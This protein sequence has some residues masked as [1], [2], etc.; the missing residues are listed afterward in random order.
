MPSLAIRVG[1][2]ADIFDAG[3]AS[4][5]GG[6]VGIFDTPGVGGA[7]D[8]FGELGE[9]PGRDELFQGSGCFSSRVKR[10][11]VERRVKRFSLKTASRARMRDWR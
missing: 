6:F 4:G 9:V 3:S 7:G 5:F 8:V 2:G 10:W 1:A 11:I